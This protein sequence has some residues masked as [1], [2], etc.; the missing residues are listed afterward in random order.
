MCEHDLGSNGANVF[1]P[2][3]GTFPAAQRVSLFSLPVTVKNPAGA[4]ILGRAAFGCYTSIVGSVIM[5]S[6]VVDGGAQATWGRKYF[7]NI[8]G[9]A[10]W[11]QFAYTFSTAKIAAGAHTL[12]IGVWIPAGSL[13]FDANGGGTAIAYELP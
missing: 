12:D 4:V 9:A 2:W 13:T 5:G 8:S 3:S 11:E 1:G 7:N 6:T 10:T